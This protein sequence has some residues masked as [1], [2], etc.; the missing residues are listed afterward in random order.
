MQFAMTA[1]KMD[2]CVVSTV[3]QTYSDTITLS[4]PHSSHA[5]MSGEWLNCFRLHFKK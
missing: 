2:Y 1:N 3:C 4:L 5:A